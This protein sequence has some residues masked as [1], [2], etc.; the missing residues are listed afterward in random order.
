MGRF[1]LILS[2]LLYKSYCGLETEVKGIKTLSAFCILPTVKLYWFG[3]NQYVGFRDR[4]E[5][6]EFKV[7]KLM[8]ID[9]FSKEG[10]IDKII[11]FKE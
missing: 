6:I 9:T 1:A 7:S 5:F 10:I 4:I 3:K 2:E 8:K 11:C